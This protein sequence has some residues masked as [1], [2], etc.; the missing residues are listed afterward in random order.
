MTR[1]SRVGWVTGVLATLVP[2]LVGAGSASTEL[3]PVVGLIGGITGLAYLIGAAIVVIYGG[4][5]IAAFASGPRE[6]LQE[7]LIAVAGVS[8][9]GIFMWKVIPMI[10]AGIVAMGATVE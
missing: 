4:K 2:R 6:H 9:G 5:A 10:V 1:C 7:G 8:V 3:A